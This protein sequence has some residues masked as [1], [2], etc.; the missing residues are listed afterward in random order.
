MAALAAHERFVVTTHEN[1]D[2][3]ALGSLL[4]TALTLRAAGKEAS[5]YLAGACP[6]PDEYGSCRSTAACSAGPHPISQG[7][8]SWRSTARTR[9][10]SDPEAAKLLESPELVID[11][12]H[13][14]DNALWAR[15]P[16]RRDASS[17]GEILRDV[18]R[19]LGVA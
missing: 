10:G 12:D 2:G 18:I 15:K 1:P 13:H 3:D 8:S 17:T 6:V 7:K 16:D 19:G 9:A 11:I 14:H 5:M 4:A